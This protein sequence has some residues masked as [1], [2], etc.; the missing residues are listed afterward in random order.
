MQSNSGQSYR[1]V[2]G[3]AAVVIFASTSGIGNTDIFIAETDAFKHLRI[4]NL[5]D[6]TGIRPDAGRIS[7][8]TLY[9]GDGPSSTLNSFGCTVNCLILKSSLFQTTSTS[10]KCEMP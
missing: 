4:V 9:R 1:K 3:I 6:D 10:N 2:A 7:G 8:K 5:L